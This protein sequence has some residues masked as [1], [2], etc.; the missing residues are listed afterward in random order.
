ML[1]RSPKSTPIR[2]RTGSRPSKLSRRVKLKCGNAVAKSW[3]KAFRTSWPRT[4]HIVGY[5]YASPPQAETGLPLYAENSVYL[6]P[7]WTGRG[8]G[9]QLT[10]ALLAECETRGLRQIVAVIGDSA[11]AASIKLHRR[12][13]FV[14]V[15]TIRSAG[16]NS[17][18][19]SIA[20]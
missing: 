5:A 9:G 14:M 20:C 1:R 13:G 18:A 12:L 19:G 6:D 7:A 8:V 11:N 15:G 16:Y 17:V 4:P 3:A 10:S 2:F